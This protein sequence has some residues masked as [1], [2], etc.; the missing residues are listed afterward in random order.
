MYIHT[1]DY[2][3]WW[4]SSSALLWFIELM[5]WNHDAELR[6]RLPG[7]QKADISVFRSPSEMQ[8]IATAR[9]VLNSGVST[10]PPQS[11]TMVITALCVGTSGVHGY[12]GRL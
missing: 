6:C 5:G 7:L 10:P 4:A 9:L 8:N 12:C 2:A 3:A 11:R 1:V